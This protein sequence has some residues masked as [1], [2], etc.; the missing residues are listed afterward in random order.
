MSSRVL[1]SALLAIAV[2][3]ALAAPVL[4]PNAPETRFLSLANAPPTLPHV[5][6]GSGAWHRPFIYPWRLVSRLE[7]RYEQDRSTRVPIIWFT[8]GHLARS[9]DDNRMPLLLT[10]T[11]GF[12][13]DVFSRVLFGARVSLGVALTAALG[14]TMFGLTIGGVAGYLGGRTDDLLMRLS[15]FVLVLPAI[16]VAL[17]LRA[18]L[19]LVVS[20]LVI[21]VL[22]AAI[23]GVVGAPFVARGVRAIIRSE[24]Q[25][26]YAV[27][28]RS[29]GAGHLRL[30]LL[31]LLPA[32]RG[33][34]LVQLMVLVPAF[35]VAEATLSYV[36]LGFPDPIASW[37]AMLHDA[38]SVRALSE[39]P[40][41]LS[42]AA[43]IFLVV[44]ALNLLLQH[45]GA[46][47]L[48]GRSERAALQ[49][50]PR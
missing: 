39:C 28:A 22:L 26:D 8:G 30:L 11:D 1:G 48:L 10:G 19:P 25:L 13:R 23:F 18:V 36:G 35:I 17:A 46:N 38:S 41:L 40:W 37:G 42:P 3:G 31:H 2:L 33:F 50:D 7:Q 21:F 27:A 47:P 43:A 9:A 49:S 4:G 32:T 29:I 20:P 5:I 34:V 12:G 16:Y 14:A 45:S 24:R 6:D 44:L 15:E